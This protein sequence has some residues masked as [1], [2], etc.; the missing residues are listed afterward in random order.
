L[1]RSDNLGGEKVNLILNYLKML[2]FVFAVSLV[3][4]S[5]N[6]QSP[7]RLLS[8]HL[9]LSTPQSNYLLYPLANK[10]NADAIAVIT[11]NAINTNDSYWLSLAGGLGSSGALY[12]SAMRSKNPAKIKQWLKSSANLGHSQSQFEFA[13]LQKDNEEK[14]RLMTL[15]AN[16]GYQPAIISMAKYTFESQDNKDAIMWLKEA[17]EFDASSAFKLANLYWKQGSKETAEAYFKRAALNDFKPAQTALDIITNYSHATLST[18]LDVAP[19]GP[20]CMQSIQFIATSL[21]S[22]VQ[23]QAFYQQFQKDKRLA[24]LPICVLTPIWLKPESLFCDSRFNDQPRLGCDLYPLSKLLTPLSFTHM[25]VFAE[26]G[27]ANVNN[28]VMY[29]DQSDTYSVFVHELAHF[30][31]FVDEYALPEVLADYHCKINK[32]PNLIL[33]SLVTEPQG[34]LSLSSDVIGA[35]ADN[36][37]VVEGVFTEEEGKTEASDSIIDDNQESRKNSSLTNP[38]TRYAPMQRANT[39][40]RALDAHNQLQQL[41]SNSPVLHHIARSRTCHNTQYKSYKPTQQMT[42][43][44][45]H[46]VPNIPRVYRTLWRQALINRANYSAINDNLAISAFANEDKKTGV[47]WS[48]L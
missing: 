31:G 3:L 8:Q 19:Q 41:E 47:F 29:L 13:L 36:Q 7:T 2:V 30:A 40:Q 17:A 27:K 11:K 12:Y 4:G 15:S 42:F 48:D 45:Y 34:E 5:D 21:V 24:N 9:L 44:E 6:C 38:Q 14:H 20:N 22:F 25:A 1:T 10:G 28:G 33:K 37:Q 35:L 43:L 18:L 26:E 46:D 23:A 32:A 16:A 39:W